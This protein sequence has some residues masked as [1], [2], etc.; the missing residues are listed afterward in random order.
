MPYKSTKKVQKNE[1]RTIARKRA[2]GQSTA[3]IARSLGRNPSTIRKRIAADPEIRSLMARYATRNEARIARLYDKSLKKLEADLDLK[4]FRER[5][6]ARREVLAI[7]AAA[8]RALS[9]QTDAGLFAP[10]EPVPPPAS[11]DGESE[12]QQVSLH[13]AMQTWFQRR[14]QE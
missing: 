8:D 12:A 11:S 7:I 1:K 4:D 6:S 9:G 2:A 5:Q 14:E 10:G 13:V 3:E